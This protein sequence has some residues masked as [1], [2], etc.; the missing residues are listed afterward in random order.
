M[1]CLWV[2]KKSMLN[3]DTPQVTRGLEPLSTSLFELANI[4]E[5]TAMG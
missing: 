3:L 2:K 4:I 5:S 1:Q